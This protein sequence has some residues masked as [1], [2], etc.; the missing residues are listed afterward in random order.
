ML[1]KLVNHYTTIQ[2]KQIRH[3]GH[4]YKSK[5]ELLSNVLLWTPKHGHI[6]VGWPAKTYIHQLC[7]DSGS[8]LENLQ[9]VNM[10]DGK[11]EPSESMLSACFDENDIKDINAFPQKHIQICCTKII[12]FSNAIFSGFWAMKCFC[13]CKGDYLLMNNK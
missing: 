9:S 6:S 1:V 8:R 5:N 11:R 2:V 13:I 3:A 4:C 7:M 12:L 10:T